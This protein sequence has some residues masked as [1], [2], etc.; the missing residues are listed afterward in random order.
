MPKHKN[1]NLTNVEK[2]RLLSEIHEFDN[3]IEP[4]SL[5]ELEQIEA[6][7]EIEEVSPDVMARHKQHIDSL[8]KEAVSKFVDNA[9]KS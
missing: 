8:L 5:E 3:Q 7:L 2:K 6:E 4:V 9:L 1:T